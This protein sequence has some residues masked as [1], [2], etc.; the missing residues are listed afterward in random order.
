MIGTTKLSEDEMAAVL[1]GSSMAVLLLL[2]TCTMVK[3]TIMV[4]KAVLADYPDSEWMY[5]DSECVIPVY[6]RSQTT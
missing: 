6:L 3:S 1:G 2:V 4:K 5:P